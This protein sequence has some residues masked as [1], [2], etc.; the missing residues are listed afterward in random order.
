MGTR[1]PNIILLTRDLG[2]PD[3]V[4]DIFPDHAV[5]WMNPTNVVVVV[6]QESPPILADDVMALRVLAC[7]GSADYGAVLE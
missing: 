2:V 5:T 3:I 7:H 1:C 4:R 6:H